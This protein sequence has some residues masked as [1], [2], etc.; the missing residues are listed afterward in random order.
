MIH[1]EYYPK[2]EYSQNTAVNIMVRG[3]VRDAVLKDISLYYKYKVPGHMSAENI[4]EKYYGDSNL[5]WAI[6]YANN[7]FD[8][9]REWPMSEKQFNSYMIGKYGSV[10]RASTKFNSDGTFNWNAVHHFVQKDLDTNI[11]YVIDKETYIK[12]HTENPNTTYAI[13]F[14]EYEKSIND[15]KRNIIVL[16]QIHLKKIVSEIRN[17]FE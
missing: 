12:N 2:V 14:Y 4:A 17:L 9:I 10:Q 7:I 13:T 6:Y 3:K 1:F 5:V 16:D 15:S 8:P 11:E